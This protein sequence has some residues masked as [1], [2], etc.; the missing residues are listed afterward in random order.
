[1]TQS[2]FVENEKKKTLICSVC[3]IVQVF[4]HI[5]VAVY[6]TFLE[7]IDRILSLETGRHFCYYI[8]QFW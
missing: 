7:V 3:E 2:P 5:F 4:F 8:P 6:I 1:M